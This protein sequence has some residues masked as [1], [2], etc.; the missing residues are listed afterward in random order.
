MNVNVE[1]YHNVNDIGVLRQG[2]FPVKQNE[3]YTACEFIKQLQRDYSYPVF[4]EKVMINGKDR[5]EEVKIEM[6][7]HQR[8]TALSIMSIEV[9]TY[10]NIL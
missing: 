5:T 10:F 2:S 6:S 3:I 7:F 4:I 9:K 8:F 1:V